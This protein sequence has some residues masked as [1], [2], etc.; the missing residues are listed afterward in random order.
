M[1]ISIENIRN[2]TVEQITNLSL[3]EL[4]DLSKQASD[5]LYQAKLTKEWIDGAIRLRFEEKLKSERHNQGKDTGTIRIE[6]DGF[7]ISSDIPK[8][9]EWDQTALSETARRIREAGE[10]VSEYIDISYKVSERKYS[11]WPEHVKESFTSAR[12]L[13]TGKETIKLTE[14]Q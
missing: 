3:Q 12:T 4:H 9:V 10:D 14:A 11:A 5:Q 2:H 6:E 1:T 7:E 13:K 8:R